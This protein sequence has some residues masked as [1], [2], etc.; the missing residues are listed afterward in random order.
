MQHLKSKNTEFQKAVGKIITRLREE[1]AQ[2]SINNFARSYGFDRGNLSKIE[3]GI[4]GCRLETAWKISEACDVKF[5]Q[6]VKLLEEELGDNF[7]LIDE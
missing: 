5:S 6:F 4:I 1:K 7:K 3:R 2:D